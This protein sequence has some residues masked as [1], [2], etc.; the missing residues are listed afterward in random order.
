MIYAAGLGTR[1]GGLT[2]ECPKPLIHVGGKPLLD[3]AIEQLRPELVSKKIINLHYHADMIRDHLSSEGIIFSDE[4]EQLLE[5]GGGLRRALP[6]LDTDLAVT[7]NSDAVWENATALEQLMQKWQDNYEALL[8]LVP[9]NRAI[10]HMGNGDFSIGSE[11]QLSRGGDYIFTGLQLIKT[12]RFSAITDLA[13][14][15]NIVWDQM[16]KGNG[17][18]GAVYTGHWCDV[19]QPESIPLAE[20]LLSRRG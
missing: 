5:T 3:H 4:S 14:S 20:E 11:N 16:A 2:A 10:G 7:I 17:L 6:L 19:G 9:A 18:F 15:T 1:M 13:F 12:E 8:L